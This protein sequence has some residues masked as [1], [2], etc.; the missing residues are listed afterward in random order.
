MFEIFCQIG[1][2]PRVGIFFPFP[3]MPVA[4]LAQA[5]LAQVPS[6]FK[7]SWAG[8]FNRT[9]RHHAARNETQQNAGLH[10]WRQRQWSLGFSD[11]VPSPVEAQAYRDLVRRDVRVT[12]ETFRFGSRWIFV[13]FEIRAM[14]DH[15]TCMKCCKLVGDLPYNHINWCR[16]CFINTVMRYDE[17][18][19][20]ILRLDH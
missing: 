4:P 7:P 16:I 19:M 3:K 12:Q 5:P 15:L 9:T 8:S 10:L 6:R 1:S 17:I 13:G 14:C 2:F 20:M 11:Q 18:M